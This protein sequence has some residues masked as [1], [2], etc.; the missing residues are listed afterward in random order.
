MKRTALL[1]CAL[2]AVIGWYVCVLVR[3]DDSLPMKTAA[4]G[5]E[6]RKVLFYQSPMHPW[7]KAGKPG[8]CTVCGMDLVP[9]YEPGGS[10]D[11]AAQNIV[12]LPE[13]SPAIIGVR[14]S[15]VKKKPLLRTLHVGGTFGENELRHGVVCAPVE[16]R[17]D[18]LAM[19][20]EGQKVTQRQPIATCFSRTLLAAADEY[21]LV[22][23]TGGEALEQ[24]KHRLERYGLVW[25]QIKAIPLRQPGDLYFGIL[26]PATGTIVKSYVAE[27][28]YVREGERLFEIAD[29]TTLWFVFTAYEQDLP[30]IQAGQM[31]TLQTPSLPGENFKG[32][33]AFINPS[34]DAST[35]SARVRVVVE[36]PQGRIKANCFAEGL[37]ETAAPEVLSVARAAVLWPGNKPRVYVEKHVGVYEQRNVKLGRGGD[38]E[39]EVLDGLALGERV[40]ASGGVLLDGQMGM[41]QSPGSA[42]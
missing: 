5:G 21:K 33:I 11:H 22:L 41:D 19:S 35:H 28:Q 17:L 15:E 12:M 38:L 3:H 29:F 10:F 4:A 1:T 40:V 9:V 39:W 18:G 23:T 42:R 6:A 37:V 7:V 2:G 20:C 30:L 13:G 34:L 14:M 32:R 26:S 16:G 31:V 25:E 36:N 24:A 8:K 27:G